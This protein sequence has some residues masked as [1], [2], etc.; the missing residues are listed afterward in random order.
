MPRSS[1]HI[2]LIFWIAAMLLLFFM[3][4]EVGIDS[5]CFFRWLGLNWCPGCGIGHAIHS[6]LHLQ[7]ATSFREHPLGIFAV[8]IIINRIIKLAFPPK[9]LSL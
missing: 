1:R 6:A 9:Q 3:N 4:A 7:L 8:V 2:E 5:F